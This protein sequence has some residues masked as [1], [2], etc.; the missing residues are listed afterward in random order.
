MPRK[1]PATLRAEQDAAL[2]KSRAS[3]IK[4]EYDVLK[5]NRLRRQPKRETTDEGGILTPEKRTK[6]TNIG[7]DLERNYSSARGIVTQFR[8]N[9]V[10]SEGKPTVG[11]AVFSVCTVGLSWLYVHIIF[12]L[13][14]AHGFYAPRDDGKGTFADDMDGD[15]DPDDDGSGH[16]DS[17]ADEQAQLE[18]GMRASRAAAGVTPKRQARAKVH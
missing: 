16:T 1:T 5:T 14:Y 12:A 13:H 2:W 15:P 4:A 3:R 18:A 9:V 17:G 6:S 10:G 7:R 8:A 11:Q